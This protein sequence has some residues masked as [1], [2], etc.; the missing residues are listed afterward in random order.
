M[1]SSKLALPPGP[2]PAPNGPIPFN[3]QDNPDQEAQ[4]RPPLRARFHID[5][6]NYNRWHR[7]YYTGSNPRAFISQWQFL[8]SQ[9]Q[10]SIAFQI[11]IGIILLQFLS[12]ASACFAVRPWLMSLRI[13][14]RLHPT[15]MLEAVFGDFVIA[16]ECRILYSA[17]W[18][19]RGL[20]AVRTTLQFCPYHERQVYHSPA[21]CFI[22]PRHPRFRNGSGSGNASVGAGREEAQP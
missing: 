7:L 5:F 10:A 11:P 19:F 1:S 12:A 20:H 21:D 14:E 9:A 16:E 17:Q 2:P 6:L 8:L 15:A 22:N 13:N 4:P 18:A 3:A